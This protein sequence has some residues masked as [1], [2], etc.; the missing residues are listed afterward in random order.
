MTPMVAGA[1][2]FLVWLLAAIFAILPS[3][4]W[5]NYAFISDVFTCTLHWQSHKEYLVTKY[6]LSMLVPGAIIALMFA[7]ILKAAH[8][9]RRVFAI[10]HMPVAGLA[11]ALGPPPSVNYRK[12]TLQAMKTLFIMVA[13]MSLLWTP[14]S[15]AKIIDLKENKSVP[16]VALTAIAWISLFSSTVNPLILLSNKKFNMRFKELV[17]KWCYFNRDRTRVHP[18]T[19]GQHSFLT[20]RTQSTAVPSFVDGPSTSNIHV[21]PHQKLV[22]VVDTNGPMLNV[23][24]MQTVSHDPSPEPTHNPPV[25]THNAQS[26]NTQNPPRITHDPPVVTITPSTP[27]KTRVPV[28]GYRPAQPAHGTTSPHAH[29]AARPKNP[30]KK[31]TPINISTFI[32]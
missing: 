31:P 7:M 21:T 16:T 8:Q 23:P 13:V 26:N 15:V 12:T 4:G 11:L 27:I 3:A 2:L 28:Y 30:V 9:Q 6:V 18:F 1:M 5:G 20:P 22:P 32:N 25:I 14:Y 17:C 24:T 19:E 29:K 10:M